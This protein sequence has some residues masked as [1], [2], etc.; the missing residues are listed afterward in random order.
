MVQIL[1]MSCGLKVVASVFKIGKARDGRTQHR[2]RDHY[3]F[4]SPLLVKNSDNSCNANEYPFVAPIERPKSLLGLQVGV[5]ADEF[6]LRAWN[7]EFETVLLTPDSWHDELDAN[8]IDIL[9]AEQGST[10]SFMQVR[11][12]HDPTWNVDHP[13]LY[14]N[15]VVDTYKWLPAMSRSNIQ[16]ICGY[17]ETS[18]VQHAKLQM[19][20]T[21]PRLNC[22]DTRNY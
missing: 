15:P 10:R 2:S 8:F 19:L 14:A 7:P 21:I 18:K 3:I 16:Q 1:A 17:S 9:F 4:S 6:S 5:I 13:E 20:E 11:R 22:Q 12:R